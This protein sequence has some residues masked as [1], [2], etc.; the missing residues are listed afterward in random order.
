M[1]FRV[2]YRYS[3]QLRVK[4]EIQMSKKAKIIVGIVAGVVAVA[5][6]ATGITL[7]VLFASKGPFSGT[8]IDASTNTPMEG[9][10]VSDGRNVVKT[11]ADGKFELK[12]YHK[13][14]FVTVT[15]PSGYVADSYYQHVE[16][17]KESYDFKLTPNEGMGKEE[18]SFI[19][20]ADTEIDEGGVGPWIDSVKELVAQEDPAFLIH[21][22]DICYEDGLKR[23]IQ[24]M[25]SE[26]MGLPVYY[27]IGNHD[28]V[29][30]KYGEELFESIYGPVWYSFEVGNTHYVVTPFQNGADYKSGYNENDRWRWLA[31]DLANTDPDK[32]VVIF[33]HTDSPS[34]DYVISFDN[35]TL[36]L[37]AHNLVAWVF[38]HYHY[39]YVYE[40]NGVVNIS[41]AQPG[42]GGIDSSVGGSRLIS[43]DG[44]GNVTTEMFYYD[45]DE[46]TQPENAVWSTQLDQR[47]L[48]TDTLVQDGKVYTATISDENPIGGSVSCLDAE[49]GAVLWTTPTQNSIKNNLIY[50]NGKIYAQDAD[51]RIYCLNAADGSEIW[52]GQAELDYSL[53]TSSAMCA[54]DAT[55]YAGSASDVTAFDA[56]T[57]SVRWTYHR[58]HGEN[59][60]AEFILAGDK[61]ILSPHWDAVVA[62]NKNTGE[63]LWENADPDLRFRSSTP[64]ALDENTILAADDDSVATF[65]LSTGEISKTTFEGYNF[66]SSGQPVID[67]NIAYLPTATKGIV[68]FNLDTKQIVWEMQPETGLVF[69][70][71]YTNASNGITVEGTPVLSGN[72]LIFGA[73]DGYVYR[74]N[75][76]DGSV[77]SK[78]NVGAPILGKVAVNAD[79]S[80]IVGD[81]AGR[82][83]RISADQ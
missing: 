56:E 21:T 18:H 41:T 39:N 30:G 68:A 46:P 31:N 67:G 27:V 50:Q 36:D 7:G 58:G 17:G 75:K 43:L 79:G 26:N 47:I 60:P 51:G 59:S 25:N 3:I 54:D 66:G 81:F 16:K 77:L 34:D 6:A 20:V 80:I 23:H 83:T 15:T 12:G 61:L 45:F 9:V 73:S 33:N 2:K 19:Q 82:V 4:G 71:C 63:M 10:S 78:V 37:K 42:S 57:G 53:G 24:D 11:D 1:I 64:I 14:R 40:Q 44:A 35:Q 13:S 5:L 38:G 70:A 62:L 48:F 52:Q 69:T 72:E 65:D 76:A 49:T 22:G 29:D 28:Y 8:V 55:I 74:L 32:K